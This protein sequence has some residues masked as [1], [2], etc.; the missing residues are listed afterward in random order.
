MNALQDAVQ[1]GCQLCSLLLYRIERHF[2]DRTISDQDGTGDLNITC[3]FPLYSSW[4]LLKFQFDWPNGFTDQTVIASSF[5]PT[6]KYWVYVLNE[7]K[8]AEE[9]FTFKILK[10]INHSD[11]FTDPFS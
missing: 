4:Y 10:L 5:Y 7:R 2:N 8:G 3:H 11:T 6:C 9:P 1:S